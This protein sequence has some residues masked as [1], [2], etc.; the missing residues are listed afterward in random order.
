MLIKVD[1]DQKK[2]KK[3]AKKYDVSGFPTLKVVRNGKK[4]EDYNG[5]RDAE[6]IVKYVKK[7]GGP[8][9]V[10]VTKAEDA[11]SFIEDNSVL[12]VSLSPLQ[13]HQVF[14]L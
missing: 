5:P 9:T 7:L 12:V 4:V 1:A 8:P 11:S 2:N 3:L 13:K 6:G 14:L 10:E